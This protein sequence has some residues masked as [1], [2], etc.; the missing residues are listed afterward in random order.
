[1]NKEDGASKTGDET[2]PFTA[3]QVFNHLIPEEEGKMWEKEDDK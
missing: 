2:I 1:M 3:L